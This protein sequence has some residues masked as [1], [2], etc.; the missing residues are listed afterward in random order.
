MGKALVKKAASPKQLKTLTTTVKAKLAKIKKAT[1]III[2][3][4]AKQT[5]RLSKVHAIIKEAAHDV[6]KAKAKKDVKKAAKAAKKLR[7]AKKNKKDARKKIAVAKAHAK[8]IQTAHRIILKAK[9]V[10]KKLVTGKVHKSVKVPSKRKVAK[11]LHKFN[12]AVKV[13]HHVVLHVKKAVKVEKA[14]KVAKKASK[15]A[16]KVLKAAK[17]NEK[18]VKAAKVAYK[19]AH[20]AVKKLVKSSKKVFHAA[21]KVAKHVAK[22]LKVKV[23]VRPKGCNCKPHKVVKKHK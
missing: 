19:K 13:V 20:A 4:V 18:G 23:D 1:P 2:K 3:T 11:I 9:K 12:R 7:A 10:G 15:A 8:I 21:G 5:A 14:K 17:L 6:K 16:K 22:A